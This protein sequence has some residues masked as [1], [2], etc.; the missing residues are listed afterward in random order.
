MPY[1][2]KQGQAI[3]SIEELLAQMGGDGGPVSMAPPSDPMMAMQ[4]PDTLPTAVDMRGGGIMDPS[5]NFEAQQQVEAASP[6]E[7]LGLF[8][9]INQKPGGSRALLALGANLLS[10]PDFF[11]GL[12]QGAMAYQSVLDE[13][14]EK[15]KPKT[16]FLGQGAFVSKYDPATGKYSFERTPFADYEDGQLTTKLKTQELI[17]GN[18]SASRE[19]MNTADNETILKRTGMDNEAEAEL[20]AKRIEFDEWRVKEEAKW[21][22]ADRNAKGSG[23]KPP[24]TSVLKVKFDLQKDRQFGELATGRM[25][26]VVSNLQTGKLNLDLVSNLINKGGLM[27]GFDAFGQNSAYQDLQTTLKYIANAKLRLNTGV[28]TNFDYQVTQ[29]ENAI[30]S[31]DENAIISAFDTLKATFAESNRLNAQ[32]EAEID[33]YYNPSANRGQSAEQQFEDLKREFGIVD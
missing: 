6:K 27:V 21:R 33:S 28:Q 13:E 12:G 14:E 4:T 31:G 18:N 9:R 20:Q 5:I 30:G 19:R 22:E 25:D 15:L 11:S 23:G 10:S 24:P 3:P 32:Q 8:G 7:R 29:L 16:Q 2:S 26:R 1:G 17:A